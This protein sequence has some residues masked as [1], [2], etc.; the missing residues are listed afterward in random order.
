MKTILVPTDFSACSQ[1]AV[2]YACEMNKALNAKIS[3]LHSSHLLVPESAFYMAPFMHEDIESDEMER[4]NRFKAIISHKY[5]GMPVD[6]VFKVGLAADSITS[7]ARGV[8]ADLIVMGTQGTSGTKEFLVGGIA[9]RVMEMA[10][11]PVLIV[12][13]GVQYKGI[14]SILF[15]IDLEQENKNE[16]H[17]AI[18]FARFFS[19]E[20][21]LLHFSVNGNDQKEEAKLL[22][23]SDK[24]KQE[25]GYANIRWIV[26][27]N[28]DVFSG[29]M[30]YIEMLKPDLL[31][32]N[33][34]R[35]SCF[36]KIFTRSLSK[37]LTYRSHTPVLVLHP[38]TEDKPVA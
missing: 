2:M 5:P 29:L 7:E 13:K 16:V 6:S 26:I 25:T 33:M 10:S 34:K 23:F 22:R 15:A 3:L 36:G 32:V 27:S 17:K 18:S 9:T 1:D 20:I 4:L 31:A 21:V 37:R 28:E 12:P 35:T 14:R 11:T 8:N 19:S 38:A 24:V 30:E